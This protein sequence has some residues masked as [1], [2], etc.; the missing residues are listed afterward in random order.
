[1]SGGSSRDPVEEAGLESFPASD[2][3]AWG[4][5]TREGTAR[6]ST[7]FDFASTADEVLS[8]VR[9]SGRRAIVTGATSGIGIE[10]ARA[11]AHAGADVTLAVR[12]VE[13]GKKVAHAIAAARRCRVHVA[14]LELSSPRSVRDFVEEWRGPLHILVNN[15]GIMALPELQRSTEGWELQFA[16]NFMGHMG[17]TVGLHD[18]LAAANGARIVSLGSSGSLFSPVNFDDLHF[19]FIPYT[20]FVAYGQ[21]KTACILLAMEANRRWSGEGIFANALNPGAIATNLQ[22]HSGGLKT[23]KERQKS[24]QQG[25]ATSVL[26]AASPLLSGVGGRYFEDCNEAEIVPVRSADYRGVA[27]YALDATNAHRLWEIAA[28]LL[29]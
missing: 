8:G 12:D 24:V 14:L 2:P 5:G 4:L 23:P 29:H 16:T 3:P 13:A 27:P 22:K 6:I 9:L 15:A 11:L 25:A 19:N 28:C 17:L 7:P 1:M 18:A 20:P 21:S 26:L 10:T